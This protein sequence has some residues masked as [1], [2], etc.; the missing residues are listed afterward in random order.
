MF[1]ALIRELESQNFGAKVKGADG[2]SVDTG[3]QELADVLV[4][5]LRSM[6]ETGFQTNQPII[7][8]NRSG[9]P[10]FV[11]NNYGGDARAMQVNLPDGTNSSFGVGLGNQGIV[12]NEVVPDLTYL[13]DLSVVQVFQSMGGGGGASTETPGEGVAAAKPQNTGYVGGCGPLLPNLPPETGVGGGVV[14]SGYRP[15]TGGPCPLPEQEAGTGAGLG[16][17]GQFPGENGRAGGGNPSRTGPEWAFGQR[18][19]TATKEVLPTIAQVWHSFRKVNSDQWSF[20]W[21]NQSFYVSTFDMS[22]GLSASKTVVTDVECSGG[23]LSVTTET[24]TI[25][26]GLITAWS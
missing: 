3:V 8:N 22:G 4:A 13:L 16:S 20:R 15:I 19:A 10:A 5:A 9:G 12:A 24:V 26:K 6:S 17:G 25:T 11:V 14:G 21:G 1:D 18:I 23:T 2:R 7:V